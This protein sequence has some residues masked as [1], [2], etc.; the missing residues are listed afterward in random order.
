MNYKPYP[1]K[2]DV[3]DSRLSTLILNSMIAIDQYKTKREINQEYEQAINYLSKLFYNL[4]K[5]PLNEID[6][7]ENLHWPTIDALA[8]FYWPSDVW[9]NENLRGKNI[10]DLKLPSWLFAKNL[11][12]FRED[13]KEEL[14]SLLKE[15]YELHSRIIP[16]F[17]LSRNRGLAA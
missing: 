7:L 5:S 10:K 14:K 1:E 8:N 9:P 16:A 4:S 11:E 6:V 17:N 3:E 12:T 2:F 13:S 15:C